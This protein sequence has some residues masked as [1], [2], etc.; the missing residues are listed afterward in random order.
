[1]EGF[2]CTIVCFGAKGAGKTYT[3]I[4][5]AIKPGVVSKS[6]GLL[7]RVVRDAFNKVRLLFVC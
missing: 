6:D 3:S 4:G 2:N 7:P 5:G 1:M